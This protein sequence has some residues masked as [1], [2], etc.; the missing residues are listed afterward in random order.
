[1][2]IFMIKAHRVKAANME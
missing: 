2:S 1:M